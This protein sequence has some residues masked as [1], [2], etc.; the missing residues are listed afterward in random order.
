[1]EKND[2]S[3]SSEAQDQFLVYSA[4]GLLAGILII[5]VFEVPFGYWWISPAIGLLAGL[6]GMG[7][8][9]DEEGKITKDERIR[10]RVRQS[11]NRP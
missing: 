1:M 7:S 3:I 11:R 9:L 6:V 4:S 10:E 8:V 5:I 2:H